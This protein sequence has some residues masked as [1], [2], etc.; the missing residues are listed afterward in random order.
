MMKHEELLYHFT[1]ATVVS[2]F[3]PL[4]VVLDTKITNFE[5]KMWN[6]LTPINYFEY[7]DKTSIKNLLQSLIHQIAEE[8]ECEDHIYVYGGSEA[9]VHGVLCNANAVY[10]HF[11]FI[12]NN[13]SNFLNSI[14][15]FPIFY[16]CNTE[17]ETSSFIDACKKYEIEY[18]LDF[19]P[20]AQDNENHKLKKVLDMFAHV[21]P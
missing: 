18:H 11:P 21:T 12:K 10:T 6:I 15:S 20:E 2:N 4:V 3:V 1:P 14:D 8:Y 9:I 16:I 7:E 17:N 19:C 13:P 5:Y